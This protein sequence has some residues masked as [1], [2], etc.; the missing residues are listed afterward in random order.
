[1]FAVS[2]GKVLIFKA[3]R[4]H[5]RISVIAVHEGNP[6]FKVSLFF[7]KLNI[8]DHL[9]SQKIPDFF[10]AA[11]DI[12]HCT[13]IISYTIHTFQKRRN[14]DETTARKVRLDCDCR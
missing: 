9:M 3:F 6:A 7:G 5:N 8:I 2:H 14:D 11:L 1:M 4:P 13:S 10:L 12:Q